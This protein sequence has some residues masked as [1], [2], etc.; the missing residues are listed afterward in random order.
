MPVVELVNGGTF[1]LPEALQIAEVVVEDDA[2]PE[3]SGL[4]FTQYPPRCRV[5]DDWSWLTDEA[6]PVSDEPKCI[7]HLGDGMNVHLMW[8]VVSGQKRMAWGYHTEAVLKR[9]GG[10]R[11]IQCAS[12]SLIA[13]ARRRLLGQRDGTNTSRCISGG[14]CAW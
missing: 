3:L 8:L 6:A 2:N 4:V 14:I 9:R 5:S 13:C 11:E 12:S 10:R 1:E 7:V